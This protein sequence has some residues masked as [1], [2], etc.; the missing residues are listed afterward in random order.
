MVAK[1]KQLSNFFSNA[2][3]FM[4]LT[5]K[6]IEGL[7][8][9]YLICFGSEPVIVDVNA[10]ACDHRFEKLHDGWVSDH[11]LNIEWGPTSEKQMN[12]DEAVKYCE[13]LGGRL[14]TREELQSLVD[15]NRHDPAI[16]TR[17]FQDTKNTWYW[18]SSPVSGYANGAWCVYFDDGD[19]N[20]FDKG[21]GGYVRPVRASQ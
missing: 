7:E 6:Q 8:G 14:P 2:G 13:G 21:D 10:P 4:D 16:D 1:Q 17:I 19:V 3:K 12:W 15:Y 20:Y 11:E 9:I 18:T 5:Q